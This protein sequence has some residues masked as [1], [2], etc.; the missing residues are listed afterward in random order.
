MVKLSE[1]FGLSL[2]K[3]RWK[4]DR[5]DERRYN[6]HYLNIYFVN[7]IFKIR[8]LGM[9]ENYAFNSF[10]LSN[11]TKRVRDLLVKVLVLIDSII[12]LWF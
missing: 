2:I 8:S 12:S 10:H 6:L 5:I 4:T 11:L 3:R 9:C 7:L 1:L